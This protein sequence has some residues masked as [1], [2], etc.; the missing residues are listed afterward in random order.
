MVSLQMQHQFIFSKSGAEAELLGGDTVMEQQT[1]WSYCSP[2]HN[3]L[4]GFSNVL[5]IGDWD[6]ELPHW[7]GPLHGVHV[8]ESHGSS[9][10]W[11]FAACRHHMMLSS[12]HS[13]PIGGLGLKAKSSL[14]ILE[15]AVCDQIELTGCQGKIV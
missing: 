5:A 2:F 9:Q 7:R 4:Q 1:S 15:A 12:Y 13:P 3:I 6:G 8:P 10:E 11:V 14:E